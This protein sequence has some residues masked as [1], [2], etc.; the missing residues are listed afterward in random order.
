MVLAYLYSQVMNVIVFCFTLSARRNS[1]NYI[2]ILRQSMGMGLPLCSQK[3][4]LNFRWWMSMVLAHPYPQVMNG[5]GPCFTL[6]ASGSPP[7]ISKA[8]HDLTMAGNKQH[9][10]L[11][12]W[13]EFP[14]CVVWTPTLAAR[15]RCSG[16]DFYS[17]TVHASHSFAFRM[18]MLT[19]VF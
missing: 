10:E 12:S 15:R 4:I 16:C 13:V 5:E 3:S 8:T 2:L 19:S 14:A 7:L 9:R 1:L 18:V 11:L 17:Q 6:S